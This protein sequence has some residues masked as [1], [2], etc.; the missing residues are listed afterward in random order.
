MLEKNVLSTKHYVFT[1]PKRLQ[2]NPLITLTCLNRWSRN[3]ISV[4][5]MTFLFVD[6]HEHLMVLLCKANLERKEIGA[7]DWL[8]PPV[9]VANFGF[10]CFTFQIWLCATRSLSIVHESLKQNK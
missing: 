6:K 3:L 8:K 2:G 4:V 7:S 9:Q 10:L 1:I 5:P